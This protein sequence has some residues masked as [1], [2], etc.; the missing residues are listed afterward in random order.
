MFLNNF[1]GGVGF[2]PVDERCYVAVDERSYVDVH[3]QQKKLIEHIFKGLIE[4]HKNHVHDW[5][6]K[7]TPPTMCI[8]FFS[9]LIMTQ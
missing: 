4:D 3:E 9:F 7:S 6:K 1:V 8:E 5:P 2:L